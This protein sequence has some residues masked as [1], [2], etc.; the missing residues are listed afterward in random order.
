MVACRTYGPRFRKGKRV[1]T[2]LLVSCAAVTFTAPA[3][4]HAVYDC[5]THGTVSLFDG[6]QAFYDAGSQ[7]WE[8]T[9]HAGDN[10]QTI[11]SLHELQMTIAANGRTDWTAGNKSGFMQCTLVDGQPDRPKSA[12]TDDAFGGGVP[13]VNG[14]SYGNRAPVAANADTVPFTM[15]DGGM[16]VQVTLGNET[17]DMVV[18]TGA[19]ISNIPIKLADR[20]IAAGQATEAEPMEFTMANNAKET[21]RTVIVKSIAIGS[22]TLSNVSVSASKGMTLLG[23]SALSQIGKFTIDAAASRLV[24]D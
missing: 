12:A 20:L 22:H 6:A 1:K 9:H 8:G 13:Y 10:G 18:D 7:I 11:V 4:A 23:L 16:H 21:N 3:H 24:F 17:I 15:F 19:G 2:L 14:W 5:A